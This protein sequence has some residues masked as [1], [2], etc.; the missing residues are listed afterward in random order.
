MNVIRIFILGLVGLIG[1]GCTTTQ[2]SAKNIESQQDVEKAL[3]SMAGAVSGKNLTEEEFSNLT[4]QI[5]NDKQAQEAVGAI[6]SS[7]EGSQVILYCP[8]DGKRYSSNFKTCP[9]HGV[10]LKEVE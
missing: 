1:A 5:R 3:R 9:E 8:T 6:T 7:L 2:N 10:Q 4:K